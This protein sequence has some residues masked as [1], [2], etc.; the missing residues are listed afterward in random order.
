MRIPLVLAAVCLA[1]LSGWGHAEDTAI[2]P[3]DSKLEQLWNEGE[4]TEGAAR[5]PDG[6]IYFS[7]IPM[8]VVGKVYKF[9]PKIGKTTVYSSDSQKSN[10]LVFDRKGRLLAACGANH[11]ARAICEITPKGEVKP[12]VQ[13]FEDKLFNAPNDIDVHP[14]GWVY[15]TD[16]FYVGPEPLELDHM[17][18]FL[19]KPED[20]SVTRVTT[21]ITKPNGVAVSPDGKTLY[22]AETNNGKPLLGNSVYAAWRMTLNAFPIMDDG[23]LGQR[24]I[25]VD[26]GKDAGIDGMCLDAAGRIYAAIRNEKRFGIAVIDPASGKELAFIPTPDLPTNC[27]FGSGD[28]RQTLYVTVG[29]GLYRIRLGADGL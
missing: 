19:W 18:V 29:K 7:D 12:L 11:G 26:F 17:S 14:R 25:V 10:G 23:T 27:C 16:P 13:K 1:T 21:D 24:R 6:A 22:V 20:G 4:F 28:D 9:D 5:G 3:K 2:V 15:M 8:E